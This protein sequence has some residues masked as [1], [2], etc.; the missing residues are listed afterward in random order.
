MHEGL[1]PKADVRPTRLTENRTQY[2]LGDDV[3]F[4][5]LRWIRRQRL[6][7]GLCIEAVN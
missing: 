7:L 2:S 4:F 1:E 5:E 3:F 6:S